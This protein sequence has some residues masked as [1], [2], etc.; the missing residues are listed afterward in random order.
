MKKIGK[1]FFSL[2]LILSISPV[3]TQ[4]QSV[5]DLQAQVNALMVKIQALQSPISIE[6]GG[7][8]TQWCHTFS[9]SLKI[10]DNGL[11]VSALQIAL[12]KEFPNQKVN[13]SGTY[14]EETAGNVSQFQEKY[15]NEIL[16]PNGLSAGTGFVGASTRA[17]LNA[18]YGCG[19]TNLPPP[20][21]GGAKVINFT[22]PPTG[23]AYGVND[24]MSV[25][26]RPVVGDFDSYLVYIGNTLSR[27]TL[28][29]WISAVP[30][31]NAPTMV[32]F[33]Y[34]DLSEFLSNQNGQTLADIASGYYVKVVAVKVG[35]DYQTIVAS[36]KSKTFTIMPDTSNSVRITTDANLQ[37][38]KV[39][40]AQ[41][42]Y[43][44]VTGAVSDLNWY[45]MDGLLPPGTSFIKTGPC[46]S[47]NLCMAISGTPTIAGTYSFN[48]NAADKISGDSKKFTLVVNPSETKAPVISSIGSKGNPVGT[49]STNGNASIH[50][51]G[52]SGISTIKIGT[53]EPQ[54]IPV[55]SD[56]DTHVEFAVPSRTQS[57]VEN[58]TITNVFGQDSNTYQVTINVPTSNTSCIITLPF[59][60]PNG[61]ANG[62]TTY[63]DD[64]LN[65]S[66][67]QTMCM[68]RAVDLYNF[69]GVPSI[70]AG[71]TVTSTY[72]NEGVVVQKNTVGTITTCIITLPF[73]A[74]N[75]YA[76]GATTFDDNYLN[77]GSDQTMC[78]K[79]AVD[80]YNFW[81]VPSI[82]A[83]KTVTSKFMRDGAVVQT[84]TIGTD[85]TNSGQG[86]NVL[87][88]FKLVLEQIKAS[89]NKATL[90]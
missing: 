86:A 25:S 27:N 77:S 45:H 49:I 29:S 76:N 57:S 67:D 84:N 9:T 1:L 16:V 63:K 61:Y 13:N 34:R 11:E 39:G 70:F 38:M 30:G 69:W 40:V 48:I 54:F 53:K 47:T 50:G 88:A 62:A 22:S 8:D 46:L 15:A 10:G 26:W 58:V 78:M 4:A 3:L 35:G 79:R 23:T 72:M 82:F 75:G 43:I 71:K 81:G 31:K 60:A 73:S 56:S 87:D 37:S 17:K 55:N 68:K 44:Y 18:I 51:T 41:N 32:T 24:L 65:A 7:S 2:L 74:P 90:N 14:A 64:Y 36:G 28:E 19:T 80:F 12:S 83:G 89:L 42:D 85:S 33:R 59:P 6:K 52:L 21:V 66:S 20:P 5:N